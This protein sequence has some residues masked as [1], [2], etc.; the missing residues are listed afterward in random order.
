MK[1]L[2]Y[3]NPLKVRDTFFRKDA[4][5]WAKMYRF[6]GHAVGLNDRTG[7]FQQPLKQKVHS[8]CIMPDYR[9]SKITYQEC[10]DNRAKE[11]YEFAGKTGKPLGIMWSGG[12]D[13][14]NILVA[15]LRNYTVVELRERIKVIMSLDSAIEYPEFYQKHVLPNFEFINA[16]YMPWLFDGSITLVS[17]EFNDQLFGS[18]M[19]KVFLVKDGAQE[20]NSN[21]S[22]DKIFSYANRSIRDENVTGVLV[23]SVIE[24]ARLHNIDIEKNSDWFWWWNFCYKW[25]TVHFRSYALAMPKHIPSINAEWESQNMLHFYETDD[26]QIWSMNNPQVRYITDWKNYKMECKDLIYEFDGNEDY[27]KNKTKKPSLN[28]IFQQRLVSEAVTSDFEIL[29]EFDPN[30]FYNKENFFRF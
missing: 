3:F 19:I 23:D 24:S 10:C 16:E 25:Q 11:L 30:D 28:N 5:A 14:T 1:S 26:F 18:D 7:Y 2:Y 21:F 15:F 9:Y 22:R 6:L 20:V 27:W 8:A 13:S 29:S 4:I 12:I 17:G